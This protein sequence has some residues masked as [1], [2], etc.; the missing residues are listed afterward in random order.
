MTTFLIPTTELVAAAWAVAAVDGITSNKIS[1]KLPDVPWPDNEFVQIMAVGGTPNRDNMQSQPV[2]TFNCWANR[3][4]SRKPPWGQ[5]NQLA[6]QIWRAT[7][8]KRWQPHPA[9]E[10]TGLP[11]AYGRAIVQTVTAVSE[12]KRV[13]A[14]PSQYAVYSV[15]VQFYWVPA[16][17][18]LAD[19]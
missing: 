1:T 18:V 6:L 17:E 7:L 14:D 13:P 15:D 9:V 8:V 4:N 10:I 12:P 19:G 2:V 5:A 16:S 11:A 3:T